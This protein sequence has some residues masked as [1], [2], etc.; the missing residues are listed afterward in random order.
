MLRYISIFFLFFLAVSALAKPARQGVFEIKTSDGSTIEVR[1]TGDEFCHQYFSSDGYPLI[2]TS[3]GFNYCTI[4]SDLNLVDSGI[5]ATS[6]ESRSTETKAFLKTI[7]LKSLPALLERRMLTLSENARRNYKVAR[8]QVN[9]YAAQASTDGPP[10]KQ[11]YGLFPMT[12]FPGYGSQKALVILVEYQDVK[13][14]DAYTV[15]AKDYFTRMLNEEGFCD[16]RYGGTGSAAQYFR[17]NSMGAFHPEFDVLGPV[18]LSRNRSYYGANQFGNDVRPIEM[19]KEACSLVDDIV[20]F[21]DYDRDGDGLIDN[22]YVYYAGQGEASGGPPESIW[23]H[24]Y[25]L[26]EAREPATYFDGVRL[27]A[28]ACSNEWEVVGKKAYPDGIGTFV[29]EFSH[30][31]GLPDLYGTGAGNPFTPGCWSALDYGPYN[32]DGKTPP[33]YGAFE[34]YAL[35]WG[36]PISLTKSGTVSLS[37]ISNNRFAIIPTDKDTEFYLLEN[38]QQT[39]W[40]EFIPHHGM[41]IWHIDYIEERWTRNTVNTNSARQLVDLVEADDI[42]SSSTITGDSFPGTADVTEF[43][44]FSKPALKMWDGTQIDCEI[45]NIAESDDGIITF[46]VAVVNEWP[47]NDDPYDDT[48]I[49]DIIKDSYDLNIIGNMIYCDESHEIILYDASAAIVAKGIGHLAIPSRGFYVV[50]IPAANVVR[51]I[52]Y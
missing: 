37:E 3:D 5:K 2:E 16:P 42:R 39:G 32:N 15:D 4:D 41:L 44:Y 29:H 50:S 8:S 34:R 27:N 28:Y 24:S 26:D 33:N 7:D 43:S 10:Y 11:G 23:P 1:L 22:I 46:D 35:G 14:Q 40:D 9:Q 36:K 45:K 18:T 48:G 51:K 30:V 47:E 25:S 20:D 49:N 17:E 52:M 21:K 6:I 31:L 19:I 38:R 13:F 12:K